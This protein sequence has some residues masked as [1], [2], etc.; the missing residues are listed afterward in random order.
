MRKE[1]ISLSKE[2]GFKPEQIL[3]NDYKQLSDKRYYLWLC[4]LRLWMIENNG[5]DCFG[6]AGTHLKEWQAY[7]DYDT[8]T[9]FETIYSDPKTYPSL[10][11]ALEKA[12]FEGLKLTKV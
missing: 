2:L 4:E 5:L 9:D 11:L 12:L 10:P 1:L 7:V 3:F 8:I 6:Q